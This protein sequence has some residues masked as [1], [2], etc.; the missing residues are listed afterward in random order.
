ME[1]TV[2]S[3]GVG[4]GATGRI[5]GATYALPRLLQISPAARNNE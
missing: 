5:M 1:D 3:L 2:V 4:M